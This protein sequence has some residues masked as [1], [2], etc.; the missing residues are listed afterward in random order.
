MDFLINNDWAN[1][2]GIILNFAAGFL[3]AP[4]LLGLKRIEQAQT[5]LQKTIRKLRYF[6]ESPRRFVRA[7]LRLNNHVILI[8]ASS[9]TILI[10]CIEMIILFLIAKEWIFS[11]PWNPISLWQPLGL[12]LSMLVSFFVSALYIIYFCIEET[13]QK[14]D[15]VALLERSKWAICLQIYRKLKRTPLILLL[16]ITL[17]PLGGMGILLLIGASTV[18]YMAFLLIHAILVIIDKPFAYILKKLI[19]QESFKSSLVWLGIVCF[20][21][22]N[23]LQLIATF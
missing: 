2:I 14:R 23:F 4:E 7:S 22:G 13:G 12:F 21:I 17:K 15:I 5:V 8:V 10:C 9:I 18:I 16:S 3:L 19:S 11:Q 20:I 6:L 1:R